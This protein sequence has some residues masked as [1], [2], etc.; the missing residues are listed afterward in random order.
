M[1]VSGFGGFWERERRGG[2]EGLVRTDVRGDAGEDDLAFVRCDDGGSEVGVVPGVDFAVALDEWSVGIQVQDLLGERAV[3]SRLGAGGQDNW[4]V[5]CFGDGGVGDHVVAENGRVVIA[6]LG[7]GWVSFWYYVEMSLSVYLRHCR[8]RLAG[9]L[10]LPSV[11]VVSRWLKRIVWIKGRSLTESFL[12]SLMNSG[13][14][15][16][17]AFAIGPMAAAA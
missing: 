14:G 10:R 13:P 6:D 17:A 1:L 8:D 15:V 2:G 9:L 5:E 4:D 7:W 16:R 12:L 11:K 3:G